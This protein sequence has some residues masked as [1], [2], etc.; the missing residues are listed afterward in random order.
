MKDRH[1][2]VNDLANLLEKLALQTERV[3]SQGHPSKLDI[4]LAKEQLRRIYDSFDE[5]YDLSVFSQQAP[6]SHVAVPSQEIK[7][8]DPVFMHRAADAETHEHEPPLPPRKDIF[9]DNRMDEEQAPEP[10][11]PETT[12]DVAVPEPEVHQEQIREPIDLEVPVV[13]FGPEVIEQAVNHLEPLPEPA[14]LIAEPEPISP[15]TFSPPIEQ[16]SAPQVIVNVDFTPPATPATPT[17]PET[18]PHHV[19]LSSLLYEKLSSGKADQSIGSRLQRRKISDLRKAIGINEK[20]QFSKELFGG[21]ITLYEQV[22]NRLNDAADFKQAMAVID[23]VAESRSWSPDDT[24]LILFIEFI[25][26]RHLT[27]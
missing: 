2:I 13:E 4:D 20:F 24:T 6:T 19:S 12:Y 15:I 23:S 25:E 17:L 18:G 22:I 26:R 9:S 21:D 5:L 11:S 8:E 27:E 3:L 14:P 7:P 1:S 10:A 16:V